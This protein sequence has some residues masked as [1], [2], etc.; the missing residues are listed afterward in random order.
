MSEEELQPQSQGTAMKVVLLVIAVL[1]V[2]AS[3]YLIFDTRS[4]AEKLEKGL[5]AAEAANAELGKQ[6][7]AARSELRGETAALAERLGVTQ[8]ELEARAGTLRREQQAAAAKLERQQKEQIS[9]V[10]GEVAGVKSEVGNVKTDV[11]ATRT[12]L[13]ATKMKLERTIGDLGMQS[14]LIAR[15]RDELEYLKHRG[16]RNYYEFTLARNNKA[17][18]PVG[19]V[20]LQLK[21]TD[22]KKAK[23]TMN[24]LADD[25]TI[26]KKDKNMLEPIQFY[27]GRDR[28]LFEL[29]VFT[30]DKD[31]VSG[32]LSTPKNAPEPIQTR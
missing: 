15:T 28:Q 10:T 11:A 1:Y 21:K 19:T 4:R 17:P 25:R 16:D 8:K 23:F 26:E 2:G 27:S 24:V 5:A 6:L 29:V 9:A 31:R 32:Y 22:P 13:E 12:D 3:L 7:G 20:S 18:T 14:G 30:M